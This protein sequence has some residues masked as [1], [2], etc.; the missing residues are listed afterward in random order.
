MW[1][2]VV[3][4]SIV[5][6]CV[7]VYAEL[8]EVRTGVTDSGKL[9]CYVGAGTEPGSSSKSSIQLLRHFSSPIT[10]F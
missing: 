8:M 2:F 3:G 10:C 7:H 6:M 5:S 9:P 1:S 4:F